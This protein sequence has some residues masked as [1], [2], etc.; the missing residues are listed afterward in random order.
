MCPCFEVLM[1]NVICWMYYIFYKVNFPFG[2]LLKYKFTVVNDY[3]TFIQGT[4]F[5]LLF[6]TS[7]EEIDSKY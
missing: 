1:F 7:N 6:F 2:N 4:L 3:N 5:T